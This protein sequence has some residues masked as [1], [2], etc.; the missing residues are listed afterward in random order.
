MKLSKTDELLIEMKTALQK[1]YV[2]SSDQEVRKILARLV[3]FEELVSVMLDLLMK[4]GVITQKEIDKHLQE[5]EPE[6][7]QR[8]AQHQ[9]RK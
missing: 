6:F 3:V 5:C 2:K 8:I 4:K 9:K 1:A 7:R